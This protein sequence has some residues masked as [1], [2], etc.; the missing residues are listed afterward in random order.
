MLK[1]TLRRTWQDTNNSGGI[2]DKH[3]DATCTWRVHEKFDGLAHQELADA[4]YVCVLVQAAGDE[5]DWIGRNYSGIPRLTVGVSIPS[6]KWRGD[7]AA[8]IYDHLPRHFDK[9]WGKDGRALDS[10]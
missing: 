3:V 8:F 6:E 10:F 1:I 4:G 9:E 7:T 2:Y 5:R